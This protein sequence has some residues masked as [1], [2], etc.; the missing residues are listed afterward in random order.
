MRSPRVGV[1]VGVACAEVN[2]V[3]RAL[4]PHSPTHTHT[5]RQTTVVV[6][7]WVALWAPQQPIG[8]YTMG[9]MMR[10]IVGTGLQCACGYWCGGWVPTAL[11]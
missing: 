11:R 8:Q 6:V 9:F 5:V 1:L 4:L 3:A 7:T 10:V 2:G